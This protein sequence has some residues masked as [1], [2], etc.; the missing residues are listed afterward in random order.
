MIIFQ[1][2]SRKCGKYSIMKV[3][4]EILEEI[5]LWNMGCIFK[6]FFFIDIVLSKCFL[7]NSIKVNQL[8]IFKLL[9]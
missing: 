2:N 6:L 9:Y 7:G 4:K 3:F 8:I 5:Y 1:L